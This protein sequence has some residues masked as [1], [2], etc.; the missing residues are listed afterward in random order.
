[1][2]H[3][4]YIAL[5]KIEAALKTSPLLTNAGIF[6]DPNELTCVAVVVGNEMEL[7]K[8]AKKNGLTGDFRFVLRFCQKIGVGLDRTY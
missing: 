7:L 3:G 5:G 6:V 8:I 1:M 2:R 4:E